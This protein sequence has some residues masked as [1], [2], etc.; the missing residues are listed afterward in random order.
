MGAVI[1]IAL[2]ESPSGFEA[3]ITYRQPEPVFLLSDRGM[4][5]AEGNNIMKRIFTDAN[6]NS[7][8]E[9]TLLPYYKYHDKYGQLQ[10][11][12]VAR[13]S[14][15]REIAEKVNWE[16]MYSNAD[17]LFRNLLRSDGTLWVHDDL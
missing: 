3:R 9:I 12:Q 15:T 16:V 1:K 14:L 6:C 2:V 13:M 8:H 10:E 11:R 7:I 5:Y 4:T 17:N